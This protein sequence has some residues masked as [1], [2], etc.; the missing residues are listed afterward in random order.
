MSEFLLYGR[1]ERRE[2]A[3]PLFVFPIILP[4]VE[5]SEDLE[6]SMDLPST[7]GRLLQLAEKCRRVRTS[8]TLALM[9]HFFFRLRGKN[10]L[11][12]NRVKIQGLKNIF[13]E[14]LLTIG[15]S[16][17][18]FMNHKDRTFLNVEGEL[19]FKGSFTM[20]KGC[21]IDVGKGARVEFGKGYMSPMTDLVIMHGMTVGEG[22]AISWGCQFLDDDFHEL[23]YEGRKKVAD[24]KIQIGSRVWIG[25][26]VSVLK[27]A[28]IPDGCVVASNSVVNK[29]FTEENCLL[30]GN[31]A[32]IVKR[33]V[34]WS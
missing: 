2:K 6:Q 18:G 30:A 20:A 15:I 3:F 10:I 27:G 4:E 25:S 22:C 5:V 17:Y 8:S 24:P 34:S 1:L 12:S 33:D 7:S 16:H 19:V 14:E 21:R 32:K 23:D 9:R 31:P 26:R 11:T 13:P 28:V 29:V